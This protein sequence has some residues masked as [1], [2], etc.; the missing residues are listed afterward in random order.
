MWVENKRRK[1]TSNYVT[2]TYVS[3][4]IENLILT[5]ICLRRRLFCVT[6]EISRTAPWYRDVTAGTLIRVS[7][8]TWRGSKLLEA[9]RN[10]NIGTRYAHVWARVAGWVGE[11]E[12]HRYCC[13]AYRLYFLTCDMYKSSLRHIHDLVLSSLKMKGILYLLIKAFNIIGKKILRN[14]TSCLLLWLRT[15]RKD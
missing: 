13:Y 7:G 2:L 11:E 3:K 8:I 9:S 10:V 15:V 12:K 4:P 1:W 14:C 5:C 6:L